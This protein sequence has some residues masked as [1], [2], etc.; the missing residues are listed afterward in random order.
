LKLSENGYHDTYN[1]IGLFYDKKYLVTARYV[2]YGSGT[3]QEAGALYHL[4]LTERFYSTSAGAGVSAVWGDS[5]N[6]NFT[7]VGLPLEIKFWFTPIQFFGLG[8]SCIGNLNA[9]K[10]LSDFNISIIIGKLY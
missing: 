2:S 7:T 4:K 6:Q 5:E 8:F 9:K 1:S 10:T 3:I